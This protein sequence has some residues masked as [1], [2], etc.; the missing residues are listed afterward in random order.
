MSPATQSLATSLLSHL[1]VINDD[2][3]APL[4]VLETHCADARAASGL[5]PTKAV[6]KYTACDFSGVM[7]D[8]AREH[9]HERAKV[10]Q[11]D[12][13]KLSFGSGTFDRY[14]SNL[15]CCCVSDFD[16]KLREARRVL[17]DGGVAAM[18]MR[19]E[20][21]EGDTAFQAVTE[22]LARFDFPSAPDREGLRIGK[23]LP[24]LKAKVLSVG[25]SSAVAWRTW[26]V[27]P[28]HDA[29]A[30]MDFATSQPPVQKFL[31]TLDKSKRDE[32]IE[33]LRAKGEAALEVGAIQVAVAVVVAKVGMPIS[34][35]NEEIHPP[36]AKKKK[37]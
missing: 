13:T 16:A 36:C 20:G 15:G 29:T 26:V 32:A 7:C 33:A 30:F 19:I 9:L 3:A 1:G 27:L 31:K 24:A 14:M 35:G 2:C 6:A 18:S 25:F 22:T 28:L 23:D 4:R 12:S 8:A 10:M 17:A 34:A 37:A 11:E 21:G 5:L